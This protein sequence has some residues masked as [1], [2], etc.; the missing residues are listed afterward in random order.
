MTCRWVDLLMI[1]ELPDKVS[2]WTNGIHSVQQ[3]VVLGLKSSDKYVTMVV[4]YR[5]KGHIIHEQRWIE[6]FHC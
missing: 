3:C 4:L 1:F 5:D 6:R 2:A